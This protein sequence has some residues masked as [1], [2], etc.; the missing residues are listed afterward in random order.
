MASTDPDELYTL[1]NLFWLGSFQQAINEGGR[2]NRLSDELKVVERD[3]FV[4]R[5][6]VG[7]GPVRLGY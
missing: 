1:R 2:L 7:P 4:Y 3:E 5:S 6:Y